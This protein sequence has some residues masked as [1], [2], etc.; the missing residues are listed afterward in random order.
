VP[1]NPAASIVTSPPLDGL[2]STRRG[3]TELW[4]GLDARLVWRSGIGL[5]ANSAT[6]PTFARTRLDLFVPAVLANPVSSATSKQRPAAAGRP[7]TGGPTRS[8]WRDS[9]PRPLRPE[10]HGP[11]LRCCLQ[12]HDAR[13]RLLAPARPLRR[14]AADTPRLTASRL[15]SCL[16]TRPNGCSTERDSRVVCNDQG[17]GSAETH[18][19]PSGR[20]QAKRKSSSS[21]GWVL[22]LAWLAMCRSATAPWRGTPSC[23]PAG[24]WTASRGV[25]RTRRRRRRP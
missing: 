16:Q 8:G 1:A 5:A 11:R 12:P 4:A 25:G 3:S 7:K 2:D 20:T 10:D 21:A 13:D 17:H 15:Q 6:R 24:D 9:N 14:V 18:V 19:G 22:A 23:A